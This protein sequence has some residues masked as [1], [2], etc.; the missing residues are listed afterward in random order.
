MIPNHQQFLEA[1]REKKKIN[2]RFYSKAD[3]GVIDLVCAPLDYGS[4]PGT[5]DG[6]KRYL[7]WDYS[8]N[9]G[10]HYLDMLPAQIMAL[11]VLGLEFDPAEIAAAPRPWSVPREWGAQHP[12]VELSDAA[13]G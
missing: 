11:Q 9:N 3:S 10:S 1:I 8:S 12:C 13:P 2:L 6:V 4:G 5:S 7:L